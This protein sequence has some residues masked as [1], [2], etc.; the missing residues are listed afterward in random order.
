M[1]GGVD[2]EVKTGG[3]LARISKELRKVGDG[4]EIRKRLTRE[5]RREAKPLV[6]I[7]RNAI[8]SLPTKG[9]DSSGL[10]K[11]MARAVTLR[12]RTS[13]RS[14]GVT[15]RVD[16]RKMP[17]GEGSL[18]AYMEGTKKRWKHPV[19]GDKDVWVS[20]QP[21]PYFYKIVRP[22]GSRARRAVLRVVA[23]IGRDIT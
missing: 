7:V 15:L 21:H 13:G 3:D 9:K 23:S 8:L 22:Y 5:I 14:A 12:V 4:R 11:R 10:R 1:V 17:E 2:F 19:Y 6:P 18:P 16:G 20:Q